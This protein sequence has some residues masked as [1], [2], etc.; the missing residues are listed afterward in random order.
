MSYYQNLDL[1]TPDYFRELTFYTSV[2]FSYSATSEKLG[3]NFI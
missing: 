2:L 3:N 1:L